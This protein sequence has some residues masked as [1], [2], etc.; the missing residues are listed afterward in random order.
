VTVTS[1][2]FEELLSIIA[3]GPEL[4]AD[5]ATEKLIAL[6]RVSSSA[7]RITAAA[8]ADERGARV[9]ELMR[10]ASAPPVE[11]LA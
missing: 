1:P 7:E 8:A 6:G 10:R 11:V 2:E 3:L 5:V 4:A 9:R